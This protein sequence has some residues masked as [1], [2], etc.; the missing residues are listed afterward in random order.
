ME[1][2]SVDQSQALAIFTQAE[3]LLATKHVPSRIDGNGGIERRYELTPSELGAVSPVV[4]LLELGQPEAIG[5]ETHYDLPL[6][7]N[8]ITRY[9]AEEFVSIDVISRAAK[10]SYFIGHVTGEAF[11]IRK[12]LEV[13]EQ[14]SATRRPFGSQASSDEAMGALAA[15][16]LV[17]IRDTEIGIYN[18]VSS[19]EQTALLRFIG[20]LSAL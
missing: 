20:E 10:T 19:R 14:A 13:L 7:E 16:N 8:D 5:I 6:I 12:Q 17:F 1:F 9:G 15:G 2:E 18:G 11:F 4:E 3:T